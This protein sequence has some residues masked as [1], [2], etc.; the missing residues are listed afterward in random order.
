M[1]WGQGRKINGVSCRDKK[2]KN[3]QSI[4]SRPMLTWSLAP[5][6]LLVPFIGQGS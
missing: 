4:L 6:R 1:F 5:L 2:K 3:N